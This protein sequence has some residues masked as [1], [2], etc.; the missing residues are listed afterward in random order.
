MTGTTSKSSVL[1]SVAMAIL[2]LF[3]GGA[4]HWAAGEVTAAEV[5][6]PAFQT[7]VPKDLLQMLEHK[8][9]V[10]V[11]VHIPYEGEIA[12]TD[13]FIPFDQIAAN[14]D[15]LPADK[16]AKIVLYCRSGRMSEIAATTLAN[17]GYTDVEHLAG[18]M[19]A[20]EAAGQQLLHK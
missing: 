1:R 6:T 13:A 5:A 4:S 10:L 11:N 16:T 20:W 12:A 3:S 8:D 19:I 2:A 7:I 15:K 14:L 9:F 18:G 17:L